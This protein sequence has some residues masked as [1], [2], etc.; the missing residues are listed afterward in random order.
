MQCGNIFRI[1]APVAPKPVVEEPTPV[2]AESLPSQPAMSAEAVVEAVSHGMGEVVEEIEAVAEEVTEAVE[3]V[4]EPDEVVA[5]PEEEYVGAVTEPESDEV[6]EAEAE[7]ATTGEMEPEDV[8]TV[9]VIEEVENEELAEALTG[10]ADAVTA[11]AEAVASKPDP[12]EVKVEAV[13]QAAEAISEAAEAVTES[14]SDQIEQIAEAVVETVDAIVDVVEAYTSVEADEPVEAVAEPEEEYAEAVAEPE[15][16]DVVEAYTSVDADEPVEAVAEP[17]EEY[18]EAVAEPEED[19]VVE[20]YEAVET[21]DDDYADA[22][23]VEADGEA[24]AVEGISEVVGEEVVPD[25]EVVVEAIAEHAIERPTLTPQD[26]GWALEELVDTIDDEIKDA[27]GDEAS[28]I[29]GLVDRQVVEKREQFVVFTMNKDL[30]AIPVGNIIEIAMPLPVAEVPN[31]PQWVRGVCNLRGEIVSVLDL[32]DILGLGHVGKNK[33][34]RMLVSRSLRE[35][36]FVTS[37]LVDSVV[38][39]EHLLTDKI[40]SATAE[41]SGT[42]S[43]YLRGMYE[44]DDELLIVL[45]LELLMAS[46][47][48]RQFEVDA[49]L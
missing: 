6:V 40:G 48:L 8:E 22:Y 10:V 20:A 24:D 43:R 25:E 31:T 44:R 17:E 23:S 13:A 49:N 5:E 38:G 1:E 21:Y 37:F 29:K 30:Y 2:V 12:D 15:E 47:D 34:V 35:E 27:F 36:D 33:L 9:E 42:V 45:N 19:D 46:D 41:L 32:R 11:V 7:F 39:I 14:E 3:A 18:A 26:K 16:D 4:P 28:A